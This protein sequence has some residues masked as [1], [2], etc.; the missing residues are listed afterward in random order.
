MKL[1][2]TWITL[3]LA[4]G[5]TGL[6]L[7]ST[8]QPQEE[9]RDPKKIFDR[10][11]RK[12]DTNLDGRISEAEFGGRKRAWSRLDVN[13]D[14]W[15][16]V[17]DMVARAEREAQREGGK[18]G[19]KK[20]RDASEAET[21]TEAGEM[22]GDAMS[23]DMMSS[24]S[25]A[26]VP[27]ADQVKFFETRVRPVLANECF[28]C[29]SSS[30]RSKGGLALDTR[31]GFLHGGASGPAMVPGDIDGSAF[32]EAIRYDD[33]F[34]SMPP[35][36]K[37]SAEEV[38]DLE[39]WVRMGAP[40]P[41]AGPTEM[42]EVSRGSADEVD[43][44]ES[45][46]RDI[47][48]EAGR[49]FWSFRPVDRV[50]PPAREDDDWSRSDIDRFLMHSMAEAGVEPVDDAT[51][52]AW[53]RRVTFDLTGL[54][55]SLEEIADYE[56][57]RTEDRDAHVVDR[58]LASV[59]Y[60]ERWGRHWLDVARYAES[61]GKERNILYPHAW[62]YRDWVLEAFRQ[63]MPYNEFLKTQLAGDLLPATDDHERAQNQIATGYLALGAKG[64]ANRDRVR[65]QLDM[66][67][68]QIDAMSQGMLGL[69]VSCA[70]C[71]DHKFDPIS[72]EDYHGLAGFA[73]STAAGQMRFETDGHN[74]R[75][76]TEIRALLDGA[77]PTVKAA[78]ADALEAEAQASD[79]LPLLTELAGPR[80][81]PPLATQGSLTREA[82]AAL[83]ASFG[84]GG[85]TLR[86][87]LLIEDFEAETLASAALGPWQREGSAFLPRPVRGEDT[88]LQPTLV[89]RGRGSINSYAGHGQKHRGSGDSFSGTLT[90][91]PFP[92]VRRY[93]HMLV[94]GGDGPGERIEV[95]DAQSGDI[96]GVVHGRRSNELSHARFDLGAAEG[97]DIQ[98]RFVDDEQGGWGN[99]GGDHL[100]LADDPTATAL[101]T[102]RTLAAWTPL[103][104]STGGDAA[105]LERHLAWETMIQNPELGW[106]VVPW[107]LAPPLR[108]SDD[109]VDSAL[110]GTN[111][112]STP[113]PANALVN[114]G[115]LEGNRWI[116]N[117]PGFGPGPHA[118]STV[119]IDVEAAES[120][121]H[122]P[123]TSVATI[124]IEDSA[125]A[126]PMWHDLKV[127]PS[128]HTSRGGNFNWVQGGRTLHSPSFVSE[129]G[130]LAHLVRGRAKV[131]LVVTG[132]KMISGPL[133]TGTVLNIDT[134]GEWRWIEQ[135]VTTSA[136]LRAHLE[137]TAI[138][139]EALELARTVD[140]APGDPRP[141]FA[142]H[143]DWW[144]DAVAA[145]DIVADTAL[146]RA[147][148]MQG[149]LRDAAQLLRTGGVPGRSLSD[150]ERAA[151]LRL[152][153][154]VA[155]HHSG[156]A[157][158]VSL[159]LAEPAA[160]L[161]A[162]KQERAIESRLAP[163][164][165][166]MDGYD[167]HILDRGSWRAP[168]AAA[169]RR[170]PSAL[171]A[172]H[173]PL[174]LDGQG[175]G[176]LRLAESLLQ[177]PTKIVQRVWVN[178]LWQGM[179]SV[180]LVTT[181]D[182]FGA[183]G[184]KPSHPGVLDQLALDFEQDGWSTKRMLRRLALSDAYARS[185]QPTSTC[186][187]KD[188]L[189][190]GL[191]RMHVRRLEAEEIRDGLLAASGELKAERFGLPVPIHL[192]A[193]MNGRGRPG[194]SGPLDGAGRRSIYLEVRR[195]F[196]HPFLTVFDWPT[197]ATCRGR[198][199]SS[200]VPAQALTL[201]NDPFVEQ[202]AEQLADRLLRLADPGARLE[203]LYL[204]VLGRRPTDSERATGEAFLGANSDDRD[205]WVDLT[206]VLFNV[207]GFLFLQ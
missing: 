66:V 52:R 138:G 89:P 12:F 147:V 162:L 149:A 43:D 169:P 180:G 190:A 201:L 161:L 100:V 115:E 64:H 51:D 152:A 173:E 179:F 50:A 103:I 60:A 198:R 101:D 16:T 114:Y 85:R 84:K 63:D 126:H 69:T 205:A 40:W 45:L 67:D 71:H 8:P 187:A 59:A 154:L 49:E 46:N 174:A 106:S 199:S 80:A 203:S 137:F 117:G 130:R 171:R 158:Q 73:L 200:N 37:L 11:K 47:D 193:F 34:L 155:R 79:L 23:G 172:S 146:G 21:G 98:V 88:A 20:R 5:S 6:L 44:H 186:S 144:H 192:T 168:R 99:I 207:K 19:G 167:E 135:T 156:V 191:S 78:I 93:L 176:R 3:G 107:L 7:A 15:V 1:R 104:E 160:R 184:A 148:W 58:L 2:T 141:N 36:S 31:A 163:V 68:E 83:D 195:N 150:G 157:R 197:P 75:L 127:R 133:H 54:P 123:R 125:M 30:G 42:I 145:G 110:S 189:N 142:G 32:I 177:S 170:A 72:A 9:K 76:A 178:R 131:L 164:A 204:R 87:A 29:H 90:S 57:D 159:D 91:Q 56:A 61:S 24:G 70:R 26:P 188:P 119:L 92:A 181:P 140:L 153:E 122:P 95:L 194:T 206:H 121:H 38:A 82:V 111:S 202:R 28:S 39:S 74:R 22:A 105:R 86:P 136:G 182:D 102:A 132:Y 25:A 112:G 143:G 18:K 65:F 118:A 139:D 96:L 175:S 185:T 166:D 116:Q 151:H 108:A 53:L 134:R 41:D 62:R 129:H 35:K 165:I 77:Q 55:P 120:P 10:F 4:A 97:R 113:G 14:G 109:H 183:M 196:P 124:A 48:L 81:A 33:P 128:T 13:G 27:T 94:N 17:E